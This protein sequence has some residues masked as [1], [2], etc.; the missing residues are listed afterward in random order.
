MTSRPF[1]DAIGVSQ[2]TVLDWVKKGIIKA[3]MRKTLG[4]KRYLDIPETEVAR[5]RQ[6]MNEVTA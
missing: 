1:A 4:G 6:A 2:P 5:V 3:T